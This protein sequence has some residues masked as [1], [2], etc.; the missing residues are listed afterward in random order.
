MSIPPVNF[1]LP[2]PNMPPPGVHPLDLLP[3]GVNP[4]GIPPPGMHPVELPTSGVP[5]LDLPPPVVH[6]LPPP[7]ISMPPPGISMP[8]PQ[9]SSHIGPPDPYSH[10]YL[11]PPTYQDYQ[12][13]GRPPTRDNYPYPG[14]SR[15]HH[16]HYPPY[17]PRDNYWNNENEVKNKAPSTSSFDYFGKHKDSFY[18]S[19]DQLSKSF[20]PFATP[21]PEAWEPRGLRSESRGCSPGMMSRTRSS[22][23]QSDREH[24]SYS[25][26]AELYYKR[27]EGRPGVE[28]TK[29]LEALVETFTKELIERGR[30]ARPEVDEMPPLQN[31]TKLCAHKRA[32]AQT[33]PPAEAAS[34]DVVY[35]LNDKSSSSKESSSEGLTDE[36]EA[37]LESNRIVQELQRKQNHPRRLHPEMWYTFK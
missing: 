2:P 25:S 9:Y 29:K 28:Q 15:D 27:L 3:P 4:L 34:G 23:R 24:S 31:K 21:K 36:D 20:N 18:S 6:S 32:A 17:V 35:Y 14:P 13:P 30:E 8:P 37:G 1:G 19:K 33:E 26:P 10:S 16:Y 22:S 5:P 11:P 12:H 7:G